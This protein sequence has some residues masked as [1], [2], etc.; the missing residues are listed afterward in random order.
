[1]AMLELLQEV[2]AIRLPYL[3]ESLSAPHKTYQIG[4]SPTQSLSQIGDRGGRLDPP[5]FGD[6]VSHCCRLEVSLRGAFH[7]AR[8]VG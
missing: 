6:V 4:P 3:S 5:R 1:M 2:T 7:Y 8:M